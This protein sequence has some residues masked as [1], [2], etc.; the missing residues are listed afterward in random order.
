[1]KPYPPG[2]WPLDA[3]RCLFRVYAPLRE[4]VTLVKMGPGTGRVALEKTDDGYFQGVVPQ[5]P[6][7]SRYLLQA[8]N[9]APMPDPCSHYQP[10]GVFGPSEVVDLQSF[11][12]TDQHYRARS[13]EDW[14]LYELHVGTFTEEGTFE[15]AIAQLDSLAE[16]GVTTIE[17]MPVAA[18]P[19]RR[20]WGYD[21]VFPFAVQHSYGGPLGLMRL[22]DACHAKGLGVVL[23]VVYNH[24]GP[25]GNTFPEFAPVFTDRYRTPWGA[26]INYDG[27]YADGIRDLVVE[28]AAWAWQTFH[29]DGFRLDAA[30][31]IVDLSAEHILEAISARLA[32]LSRRT[33]RPCVL[34]A[35]G[36]RNDPRLVRPR[37]RGGLG[38]D[39]LWHEDF[40]H[41]MHALLTGESHA[42]F[43]DYGRISDLARAYRRGFTFA[44]QYSNYRKYRHGRRTGHPSNGSA[45]VAYVQNHDQ[46]GNRA[47]GERLSRLIDGEHLKLAAAVTL[48]SPFVP[49]L[50]MGEEYGEV[51]PFQYFTDH[52]GQ[53]L[54]KSVRAGRAREFAAF[55]WQGE[56]PDP[57][58]PK[59]FAVSHLRRPPG[60]PEGLAL[61]RWY[62]ELI[63]L[64]R[65]VAALH[66]TALRHVQTIADEGKRVLWVR[67]ASDAH[68]AILAAAFGQQAVQVSWPWPDTD[69]RIQV[70][71][72][73]PRWQGPG[74]LVPERLKGTFTLQ[75]GQIVLWAS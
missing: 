34:I 45:F 53:E 7:G 23:D 6:T 29:L 74:S 2:A 9:H 25:E 50:F 13:R 70:D 16:L 73:E 1:M 19:G 49:M 14:I 52:H 28:Q 35:E 15:S 11:D 71:S 27:A 10:Q 20:N 62:R 38:L 43:G 4:R 39:M 42:Y 31:E 30:H 57:Q 72:A 64:R 5:M 54:A 8:D 32:R 17:L 40:H 22:V 36:D 44:G 18:F 59:T 67:R 65:S 3:D 51:E 37:A 60:H 33:N 56:V 61:W 12:W 58:D 24:L 41:A 21:G 69:L 26:A 75:P 47:R 46:V 63:R 66:D 48:L 68:Q 55:A